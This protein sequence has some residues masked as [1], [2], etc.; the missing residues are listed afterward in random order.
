MARQSSIQQIREATLKYNVKILTK[1]KVQEQ[2]R[3]MVKNKQ[4]TH[5]KIMTEEVKK[6]T[7]P[8]KKET[9]KNVIK[10]LKKN[11]KKFN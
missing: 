7:E 11:N 9:Y 1:N 8:L 10:H 4:T 2:N 6:H 3:E 5:D